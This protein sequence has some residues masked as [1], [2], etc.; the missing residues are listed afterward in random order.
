[1]NLP[2][3]NDTADDAYEAWRVACDTGQCCKACGHWATSVIPIST[4]MDLW[5]NILFRCEQCGHEWADPYQHAQKG[6]IKM[7]QLYEVE[8][9]ARYTAVVEA[10]SIPEAIALAH[11]DRESCHAHSWIADKVCDYITHEELSKGEI[12]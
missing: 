11:K 4:T 9:V 12:K 7:R 3:I 8:L 5:G 10:S 6:E 1:M 2:S